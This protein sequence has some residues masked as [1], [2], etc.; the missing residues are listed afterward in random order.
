M[1]N[2]CAV[3]WRRGS[4]GR[5]DAVDDTIRTYRRI[6]PEVAG[7]TPARRRRSSLATHNHTNG[8]SSGNRPVPP[9]WQA[10]HEARLLAEQS[11]VQ[12][13]LAHHPEEVPHRHAQKQRMADR[14][15]LAVHLARHGGRAT[16]RWLRADLGWYSPH[17]EAA[18]KFPAWFVR[19]GTYLR[20]TPTGWAASKESHS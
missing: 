2:W 7:E 6:R 11:R 16:R 8:K 18:I 10:Q 17:L 5:R 13:E 14:V 1:P 12:T 20:L 4:G 19:E 3:A 9:E 15:A